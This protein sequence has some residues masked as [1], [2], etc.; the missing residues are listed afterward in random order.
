[1]VN[2]VV[3]TWDENYEIAQIAADS[4]VE[5]YFAAPFCQRDPVYLFQSI[6]IG[7]QHVHR[8]IGGKPVG[9]VNDGTLSGGEFTTPRLPPSRPRLHVVPDEAGAD[10][11]S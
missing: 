5:I 9:H 8:Q 6:L 7:P 11:P 1:M 3:I 2:R 10:D 4:P